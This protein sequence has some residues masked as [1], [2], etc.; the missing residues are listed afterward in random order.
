MSERESDKD[1]SQFAEY[2]RVLCLLSEAVNES[3]AIKDV[4]EYPQSRAYYFRYWTVS[5]EDW[6]KSFAYRKE[7]PHEYFIDLFKFQTSKDIILLVHFNQSR[8]TSWFEI[9]LFNIAHLIFF[10]AKEELNKPEVQ[11]IFEVNPDQDKETAID[12][13]V[14][15][16]LRKLF[17][18]L[19]M[20][21]FQATTRAIHDSIL[22][23]VKTDVEHMSRLTWKKLELPRNFE[24][25]PNEI[26]NSLKG[27]IQPLEDWRQRFIGNIREIPEPELIK[28]PEQ[29]KELSAAYRMAK[30]EHRQKKEKFL[31]ASN[32]HTIEDWR[33]QWKKEFVYYPEL[34]ADCLIMI[35]DDEMIMPRELAYQ[36]LSFNWGYSPDHM[37]RIINRQKGILNVGKKK[38]AHRGKK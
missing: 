27:S 5:E 11:Q 3:P 35:S 18:A 9:S 15:G 19:P 21:V 28:L 36:H 26:L 22:S 30:K 33:E 31:S 32:R 14:K 16:V 1:N 6:D 38:V 12:D 4:S 24:Y 10:G 20:L 29:Y 17:W 34:Y 23:Y 37:R 13:A 2:E 25:L 7:K 8:F